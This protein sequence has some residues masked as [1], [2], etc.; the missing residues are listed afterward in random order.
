MILDKN[1]FIVKEQKTIRRNAAV[2]AGCFRRQSVGKFFCR[3]SP[4]FAEKNF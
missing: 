3:N 2:P 4:S 1:E